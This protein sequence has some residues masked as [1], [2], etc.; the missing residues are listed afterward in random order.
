[1]F[2][3]RP[4]FSEATV[5]VGMLLAGPLADH[6]FEPAM[7]SGGRLSSLFGWLVGTGEGAGMALIFV[8]CGLLG[9]IIS[10]AA[11]AFPAVRAIE[12]V[13]PDHDGEALPSSQAS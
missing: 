13:L 4:L 8:L 2:A 3:T 10:L 1:M 12:D 5:L 11:Y 7:R 6:V 9:A